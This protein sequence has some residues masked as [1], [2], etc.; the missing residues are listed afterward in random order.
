MEILIDKQ[1][2]LNKWKSLCDISDYTTAFQ[3]PEFFQLFNNKVNL[4]ARAIALDS[5]GE[6]KSL[7]VITNQSESGIKK[8]F[9]KRSIIYGGPVIF[10]IEPKDFEFFLTNTIEVCSKGSIYTEIRCLHDYSAFDHIFKSQSWKYLPY[11]NYKVDCRNSDKLFQNLSSNRKRQIKKALA[12]GVQIKEAENINEVYRFYDIL[13]HLY[14]QKVKRPLLPKSIFEEFFTIEAGKILLVLSNNEIIGGI[15][16]PILQNRCMYEY[17]I[18]G[19]DEKHKELFPSVM[20]TWAAMEFANKN[21]IPV[22]DFMG[23]GIKNSEYGVRDFKA[24]FGGELVEYG[25][26]LKINKPLLYLIGKIG[27]KILSFIKN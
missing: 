9:S 17:Y 22:F 14:K 8:Y 5:E 26:Y 21:N 13:D 7:C 2:P 27:V 16:C 18:C 24:R 12:G 15:M 3:T 10:N 1:I 20:A 25:R 4:S 23:A 11:Q 6:L 19:L